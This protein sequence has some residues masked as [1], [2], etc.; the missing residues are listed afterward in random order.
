MSVL[1]IP[2][3]AAIA[4][5]NFVRARQAAQENACVNNLRMIDSTKQAWAQA[6]HKTGEE[7][8]TEEDLR[9]LMANGT[10]PVCPAGGTYTIHAVN[11]PPTCSIPQHAL[12]LDRPRSLPGE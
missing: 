12:P 11:E 6:H 10:W 1:I 4:I 3:M 7:M 9:L 8:P 5:P 2:L